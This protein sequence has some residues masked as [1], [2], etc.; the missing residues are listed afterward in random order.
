MEHPR[1]APRL[2]LE[3]VA[4][5]VGGDVG[6]VVQLLGE[7]PLGGAVDLD[8]GDVPEISLEEGLVPDL[9]LPHAGADDGPGLPDLLRFRSVN[10]VDVPGEGEDHRGYPDHREDLLVQGRPVDEVEPPLPVILLY[11]RAEG[12]YLLLPGDEHCV[13]Q[14]WELARVGPRAVAEI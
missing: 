6:E 1:P 14:G 8:G 9:D 11:P 7:D 3:Q 4:V 13:A 5:V 10:S 2:H 12:V